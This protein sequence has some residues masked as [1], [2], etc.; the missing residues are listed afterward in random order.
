M[1]WHRSLVYHIFTLL[2]V[3]KKY[4]QIKWWGPFQLWSSHP[5]TLQSSPFYSQRSWGSEG[6][7]LFPKTSSKASGGAGMRTWAF[8]FPSGVFPTPICADFCSAAGSCMWRF[9]FSQSVKA[10]IW[11]FFPMP[12]WVPCRNQVLKCTIHSPHFFVEKYTFWVWVLSSL[13]SSGVDLLW[14]YGRAGWG[15]WHPV[16]EGLEILAK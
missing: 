2:L 12:S 14:V 15:L 9:L 5:P 1:N 7:I 4:K 16:G 11:C 6:N 13:V 8:W 3:K 10:C